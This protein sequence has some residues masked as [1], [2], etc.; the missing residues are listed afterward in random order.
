MSK[1]KTTFAPFISPQKFPPPLLGVTESFHKL[2]PNAVVSWANIVEPVIVL[3][4][5]KVENPPEIFIPILVIYALSRKF[6]I[7]TYLK[8]L[9]YSLGLFLLISLPF[10][11]YFDLP[12][13]L[14][15]LY[16]ERIMPGEIG[17]LTANAFN[18]WWLIDPGKV[19][20]GTRYFYI[21]A[22]IWGLLLTFS[23][24]GLPL[25]RMSYSGSTGISSP[26]NSLIPGSTFSS[27]SDKSG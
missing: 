2:L 18:F 25:I 21:P 16:K 14:I 9:A 17:Y 8:A 6:E 23:S 19:L 5:N 27:S 10:H 22:R 7:T 4:L 12:L 15:N 1:L 26:I 24:V 13:W 20:D 11:P 3:R